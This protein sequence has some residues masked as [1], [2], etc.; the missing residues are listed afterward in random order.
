VEE[1]ILTLAGGAPLALLFGI[2]LP[3]LIC[4]L[5]HRVALGVAL[6]A[7]LYLSEA[8]FHHFEGIKLG[9]NLYPH[10]AVFSALAAAAFLRL[11]FASDFPKRHVLW[12]L[13]GILLF[14]SLTIGLPRYGTTAG[15]EFR[16][17]FYFWTGVLYFM[18]FPADQKY[19]KLIVQWWKTIAVA[20][21]LLATFRW[22]AEYLDWGIKDMW[23]QLMVG[24]HEAARVIHAGHAVLLV[25]AVV[26]S[27][28]LPG[29]S[30][31][32][33][34]MVWIGTLM[35]YVVV[36]QHRTAWL[37]GLCSVMLLLS[38]MPE[39]RRKASIPLLAGSGLVVVVA[40]TI[41]AFG[42]LDSIGDAVQRSAVSAVQIESGTGTHGE[43]IYGWSQL[44]SGLQPIEW[45]TGRPFGSGWSRFESPYR[46]QIIEYFPH[47]LY[48][49]TLLR[50]GI[51]GVLLLVSSYIATMAGLWSV[52]KQDDFEWRHA[53]L[54]FILL[55]GNLIF[56]FSYQVAYEQCVIFGVAM[57]IARAHRLAA[58]SQLSPTCVFQSPRSRSRY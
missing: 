55:L 19:L 7:V 52:P 48:L 24:D 15:V 26:I 57:S 31:N 18:S 23:K 9:L 56:Y 14:T 2:A 40:G 47:N 41:T 1:D 4:F 51:F 3:A 45:I 58:T 42:G 25:Q 21:V 39:I 13:F 49:A 35:A 29:R 46:P 5:Y 20:L 10:D 38:I 8:W 34:H 11:M 54:L 53:K 6:V 37:V 50:T 36:L 43:R 17:Y 33:R 28:L 27:I 16:E 44:I 30:S 32:L 12:L 22:I